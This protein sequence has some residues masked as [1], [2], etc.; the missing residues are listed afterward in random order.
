MGQ[1]G[2]KQQNVILQIG[3]AEQQSAVRI[4]QLQES[5]VYFNLLVFF[6]LP[7]GHLI[8]D[9][10]VA[11]PAQ[12]AL[13]LFFFLPDIFIQVVVGGVINNAVHHEKN[14]P[15]GKCGSGGRKESYPV[16]EI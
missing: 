16:S 2:I 12:V 14:Q 6:F 10:G 15:D 4:Q 1:F 13:Y 3:R 11:R 7:F 9:N 5:R 8:N